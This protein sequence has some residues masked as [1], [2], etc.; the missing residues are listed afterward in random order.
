MVRVLVGLL[1][2]CDTNVDEN[3]YLVHSAESDNEEQCDCDNF[4]IFDLRVK[5]D[6]KIQC[7]HSHDCIVHK[8][9]QHH[10]GRHIFVNYS[11]P[12]LCV[13]W[14]RGNLCHVSIF[15][16]ASGVHVSVLFVVIG[17]LG[18]QL[19]SLAILNPQVE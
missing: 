18:Q 15:C 10:I 2:W 13:S 1:R 17:R 12:L 16:V 4:T 14:S 9:R 7:K 11:K 5:V 8:H 3:F 19:V 6:C